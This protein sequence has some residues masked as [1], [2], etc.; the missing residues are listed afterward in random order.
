[1]PKKHTP[2]YTH[3]KPSYVHPSLQSSR[4]ESS[5]G[6]PTGP[7]TVNERIAQLR[8][9]QTPRATTERRDEVTE[10]VTART[11]P[12][13][14]RRILQMAEVDA[15]PPK[16]GS[17]ATRGPRAGARPPPGPATPNSWLSSSRHAPEH[18]P[19]L[20]R[21]R[22][23]D[24]QGPTRMCALARENDTEFK[25]FPS[26]RSLVHHS[27]KTFAMNWQELVEYEQHYLC[28]LPLPL[29]EVLLSYLG[30]YGTERCMSMKDMKILFSSDQDA[31]GSTGS[32]DMRFLDLTGLLGERYSISDLQRSLSRPLNT[33]NSQDL[34]NLSIIS[35][36]GKEKAPAEV[37]ESWEDEASDSLST[38]LLS[39]LSVPQFPNLTRLSLAHPGRWAS[40]PDLLA[41]SKHLNR[42]THLSLAY[43]PTP[44]MTPNAVTTS[45]VS[46]HGKF[47]LG[48]SHFYSELDNDWHEA[49]NILRRLSYST[50]CL[51]WLDL[52]GCHWHKAL[53]WDDGSNPYLR[54]L[55][56]D[57]WVSSTSSP[58]PDWNGAWRQI[59][60][61]N[62]FQ[63]WIPKDRPSVQTLPSGMI[64]IQLLEWLN[65]RVEDDEWKLGP[66]TGFQ[67]LSWM[68]REEEARMVEYDI[69]KIRKEGIEG[70]SGIWCKVDH[71][72][73]P[74]A[75]PK[76]VLP[77]SSTTPG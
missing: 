36:K 55:S 76:K 28:A 11:V 44:H 71:G 65:E 60:Y 47:S 64:P 5:S 34:E 39:T 66:E 48:G 53:T 74:K 51:T 15:P 33:S 10:V 50:Y 52:E 46:P 13:A 77:T 24:G 3:T 58:G 68:K 67:V 57:E 32:D 29:K 18:I 8:R 35:K 25:R 38:P 59:S 69:Q 14:L 26:T 72:W 61:L 20:K 49:A 16:A 45:M 12:P 54:S 41:V 42:L 31:E 1:M 23:R 22:E 9:E 19:G 73:E 56:D 62:L 30:L 37:V 2:A 27:L 63:G 17:R 75:R 4:S 70:K 6:G 7:Q 21:K 40:W 43:W